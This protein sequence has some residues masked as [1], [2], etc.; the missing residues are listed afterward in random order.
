MGIC[1]DDDLN[2][3]VFSK[4][5][6][7]MFGEALEEITADAL[8]KAMNKPFIP[9]ENYIRKLAGLDEVETID[10]LTCFYD[11]SYLLSDWG[12]PWVDDS[13]AD[14]D[15]DGSDSDDGNFDGDTDETVPPS[16]DEKKPGESPSQA[17]SSEPD[18]DVA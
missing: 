12:D 8:N 6:D 7:F 9:L 14:D 2:N 3:Y 16:D 15:S 4:Y 5:R 18:E 13:I 10:K 17:G 11:A 1:S